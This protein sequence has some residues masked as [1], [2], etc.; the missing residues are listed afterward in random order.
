[1]IE[2]QG[3]IDEPIIIGDFY[4]PLSEI[5]WSSRQNTNKELNNP[6]N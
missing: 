5:D 4:T 2:L 3:E 1:M 6:I